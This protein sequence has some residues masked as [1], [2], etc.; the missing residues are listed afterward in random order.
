LT[1]IRGSSVKAKEE[2]LKSEFKNTDEIKQ[3]VWHHLVHGWWHLSPIAG[4]KRDVEEHGGFENVELMKDVKRL[5]KP[6]HLS[7]LRF[8]IG[9]DNS[10]V[11]TANDVKSY[12][13]LPKAGVD[14]EKKQ[15][16]S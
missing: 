14:R 15:K 8:I 1:N 10:D 5:N 9:N 13:A 6:F 3:H 2:F 7:A 16:S 12:F 4:T 11:R